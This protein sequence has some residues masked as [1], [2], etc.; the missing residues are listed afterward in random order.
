ME[1]LCNSIAEYFTKHKEDNVFN[2]NLK[3]IRKEKG[4]TQEE[5]ATKVGVVRQ[6]VSKW[7]KGL[8]VPDADILRKIAETLDTDI[9]ILLGDEITVD[10][11]NFNG[12]NNNNSNKKKNINNNN[13]VEKQLTKISEQLAIKNKRNRKIWKTIGIVILAI[14]IFNIFLILFN[15]STSKSISN[16]ESTVTIETETEEETN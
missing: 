10:I 4:Y 6:T 9:D 12:F 8:S 3:K 1:S 2:E 7:E 5:L 16:Y 15:V 13:V 14:V 11:D